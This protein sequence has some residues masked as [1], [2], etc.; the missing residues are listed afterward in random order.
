MLLRFRFEVCRL[1]L[2]LEKQ[3]QFKK[4]N[5]TEINRTHQRRLVSCKGKTTRLCGQH[6]TCVVL[7]A[8]QQ[9]I[10]VPPQRHRCFHSMLSLRTLLTVRN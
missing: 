7:T 3:I 4:N 1:H 10:V 8:V 6:T 9:C 5:D 2:N